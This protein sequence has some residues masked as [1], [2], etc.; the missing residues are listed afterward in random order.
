MDDVDVWVLVLDRP[1]GETQREWSI[2]CADEQARATRL[3]F[4]RDRS[5]FVLSRAGLREVLA[6]YLDR[7]APTIEFEL[8]PFGKPSIVEAGMIRFSLSR[9]G[10]RALVAV[11]SGREVGVDLEVIRSGP[12]D[13]LAESRMLSPTE[14]AAIAALPAERRRAA[15]FACWTRKEAYLKANGRG[16]SIPL[17]T[18]SVSV[19]PGEQDIELLVPG[20]PLEE[21]HWQLIDIP[22]RDHAAAVAAEGRD[23]RPRLVG[24]L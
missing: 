10:G 11:A 21:R 7:S 19:K 2:L 9:S 8:G 6:G 18:F 23:W 16:L 1:R 17:E 20:D 4:A 22:M 14:R 3:R 12:A 5:R 15:F 13:D 24:E